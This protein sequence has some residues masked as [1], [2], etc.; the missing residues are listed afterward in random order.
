[1]DAKSVNHNITNAILE[2]RE[3]NNINTCTSENEI[4][5]CTSCGGLGKKEHSKVVNYQN[6]DYDYWYEKCGSCN[7]HGRVNKKKIEI[8]YPLTEEDLEVYLWKTN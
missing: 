7:G 2:I 3:N 5:I 6:N 1:M 4:I 8:E